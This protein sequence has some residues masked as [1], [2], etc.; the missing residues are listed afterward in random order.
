MNKKLKAQ[1]ELVANSLPPLEYTNMHRYLEK[2]GEEV[3]AQIKKEFEAEGKVATE[4][5]FVFK[6]SEDNIE[7]PINPRHKYR[8]YAGKK[9]VNHFDKLKE[10]YRKWGWKGVEEYQKEVLTKYGKVNG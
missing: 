2:T 8:I 1:L 6:D 5:D 9:L 7:K 10:V 4:A 3:I